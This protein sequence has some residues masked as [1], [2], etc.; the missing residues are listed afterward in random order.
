MRKFWLVIGL[1]IMLVLGGYT[2]PKAAS[3]GKLALSYGTTSVGSTGYGVAIAITRLAEKY[4]PYF[5]LSV[6]TVGGSS[7]T[8]K[9][10]AK[11]ELE[12]GLGSADTIRAAARGLKEFKKVGNIPVCIMF[13]GDT[14]G[15]QLITLKS[16]IKT[17]K[18][19]KGRS[20]VWYA[21]ASSTLTNMMQGT[22]DWVVKSYGW[23]EKD[24]T[25]VQ[26]KGTRGTMK[27]LRGGL[28]DVGATL[29]VGGAAVMELAIMTKGRFHILPYSEEA[30]DFI[31]DKYPDYVNAYV[32][33]GTYESYP[34]ENILTLGN[35]TFAF[36]AAEVSEDAIYDIVKA[37][38]DH[39]DE[40][41]KLVGKSIKPPDFTL[42]TALR[43]PRVMPAPFHPGAVKYFKEKGIWTSELERKQKKNLADLGRKR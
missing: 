14:R 6:E 3:K 29:S 39:P 9:L 36:A 40:F 30:L 33:K 2:S 24:I 7:A 43:L 35:P 5:T 13:A 8:M 12:I 41:Q 4:N 23:S 1:V 34:P 31:T 15:Y 25:T 28:A 20:V 42:E 38:F 27:S 10:L 11:K 17:L 32:P 22:I 19:L 18:D 26:W 21:P 16:D 37:V